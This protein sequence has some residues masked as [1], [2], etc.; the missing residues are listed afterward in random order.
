MLRVR[1]IPIAGPAALPAANAERGGLRMRKYQPETVIIRHRRGR[2]RSRV[3]VGLRVVLFFL[4]AVALTGLAGIALN[5]R[6]ED[7]WQ[8]QLADLRR[9]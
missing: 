4:A 6:L 5:L 9:L 8:R 2:K 3:K 7:A 1:L